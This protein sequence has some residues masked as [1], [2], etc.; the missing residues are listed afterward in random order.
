M[1]QSRACVI[2]HGLFDG[3]PR[4]CKFGQ[5]FWLFV[6]NSVDSRSIFVKLVASGVKGMYFEIFKGRG[7]GK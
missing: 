5:N 2:M 3:L 6:H 1:G 7:Q 4:A